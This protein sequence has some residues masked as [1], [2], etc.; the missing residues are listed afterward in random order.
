MTMN[1]LSILLIVIPALTL[2]VVTVQL[3]R[4][5]AGNVQTGKLVRQD[6]AGQIADLPFGN[7][8]ALEGVDKQVLLHR[9]PLIDLKQDVARCRS[10][11]K[12]QLCNQV[13]NV[14]PGDSRAANELE[15]CPNMG[16]I[17]QHKLSI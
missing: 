2:V 6:L 7:M 3:I 17:L 5:M 11:S 12:T 10:C 14:V 1:P 16:A 15:F 9:V 13:L 4:T 8:L